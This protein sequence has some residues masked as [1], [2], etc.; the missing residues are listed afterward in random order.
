VLF[1]VIRDDNFVDRWAYKTIAIDNE[2]GLLCC[3][4]GAA[5]AAAAG[6]VTSLSCS[7]RNSF[8]HHGD[9]F[10]WESSAVPTKSSSYS[11]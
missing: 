1:F 10:V 2:C 11:S 9:R 4:S 7:F 6:S 8:I 3:H 5:P